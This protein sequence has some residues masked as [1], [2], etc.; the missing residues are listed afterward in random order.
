M[1]G[2]LLWHRFRGSRGHE[3]AAI[4]EGVDEYGKKLFSLGKLG[5][6]LTAIAVI[7]QALMAINLLWPRTA[8]YDL[9]GHTWW[10]KWSGVLFI[11]ITL[12]VGY[13]VHLRLRAGTF[14]AADASQA[15][16]AVAE[17]GAA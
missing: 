12:A 9:T 14:A 3:S 10:L 7:Y 13:L 17:E 5:I 4:A 6:P 2:P 11:A 8:I 1:T 16:P 15:V